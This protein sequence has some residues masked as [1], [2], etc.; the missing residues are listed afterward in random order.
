MFIQGKTAL[1][2]LFFLNF[3]YDGNKR[4][5]IRNSG[6]K[7]A[8]NC[9]AIHLNVSLFLEAELLYESLCM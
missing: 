5:G 7:L 8:L 2:I 1:D 6:I 3:R 4:S 9:Y